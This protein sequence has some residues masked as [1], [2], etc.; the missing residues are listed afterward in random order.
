[1][2]LEN[3]SIVEHYNIKLSTD[4]SSFNDRRPFVVHMTFLIE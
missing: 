2:L 3:I 1:M 4:M